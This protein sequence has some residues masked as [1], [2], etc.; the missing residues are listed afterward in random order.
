MKL[1]T[2][3]QLL[4]GHLKLGGA[5]GSLASSRVVGPHLLGS[6]EM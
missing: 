2:G 3:L 4:Q 5:G 1:G 6:P